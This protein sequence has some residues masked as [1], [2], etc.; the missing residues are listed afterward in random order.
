[1]KLFAVFDSEPSPEKK[2]TNGWHLLPVKG[3]VILVCNPKDY[4]KA[5]AHLL[6]LGGKVFPHAQSG[7]TLG[8]IAN[9]PALAGTGVAPTHA[10]FKA[11]L[12]LAR[13]FA[14]PMLDPRA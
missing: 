11:A 4:A 3:G 9:H 10:T 1:M 14:W 6:S 8:D 13:H 7:E 2:L 12:L 5:E